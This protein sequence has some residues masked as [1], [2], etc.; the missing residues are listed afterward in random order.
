MHLITR[1]I[2]GMETLKGNV[3]NFCHTVVS[4][5]GDSFI[6]GFMKLSLFLLTCL[7]MFIPTWLGVGVFMLIVW[8]CGI[9]SVPIISFVVVILMFI[10]I[11][12]QL[13]L[14][15]SGLCIIAL[16]LSA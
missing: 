10:L 4:N 15:F 6:T 13:W 14:I 12:P 2:N 11:V 9:H 16:I 5:N 1:I 7:G 8:I 3:E